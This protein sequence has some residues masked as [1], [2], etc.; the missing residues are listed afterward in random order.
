[1]T[2]AAADRELTRIMQ[3]YWASFAATGNPNTAGAPDW[4]R[5]AAPEFPVQE[6]GDSVKAV[7]APEPLLCGAFDTDRNG[8]TLD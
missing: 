7:A 8:N 4:P 3:A 5:F 6:L 1:M 2:T